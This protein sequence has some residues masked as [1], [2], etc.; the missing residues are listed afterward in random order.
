MRKRVGRRLTEDDLTKEEVLRLWK[1]SRP[2]EVE[3]RRAESSVLSV[4]LPHHL[5]DELVAEAQRQGKGPATLA[6]ELIEEGLARKEEA[7]L[8]L[9]FHRLAQRL[10]DLFVGAPSVRF[11]QVPGHVMV[12][13]RAGSLGPSPWASAMPGRPGAAI[14]KTTTRTPEVHTRVE[15]ERA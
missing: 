6:R 5:F 3:R 12:Q 4:R 13:P 14:P 9:L 11:I 1:R 2:V 15:V 10:E 8:A 7:S